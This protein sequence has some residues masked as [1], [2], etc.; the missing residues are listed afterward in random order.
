MYR[1]S[2]PSPLGTSYYPSNP[3]SKNADILHEQY[4]IMQHP[5]MEAVEVIF[6]IFLLFALSSQY[7]LHILRSNVTYISSIIAYN[8]FHFQTYICMKVISARMRDL[9]NM[10]TKPNY[11]YLKSVLLSSISIL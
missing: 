1:G 3:V 5:E 7:C 8:E 2:S 4:K 9:E 10:L 11:M 6:C